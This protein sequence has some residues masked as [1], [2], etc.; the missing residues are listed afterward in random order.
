MF[1]VRVEC[2]CGHIIAFYFDISKGVDLKVC[3]LKVK[4]MFIFCE[5]CGQKI[6][7]DITTDA[8]IA[9]EGE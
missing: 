4:S 9:Q 5:C 3:S 6:Y 2:Q 1:E 8:R 7:C